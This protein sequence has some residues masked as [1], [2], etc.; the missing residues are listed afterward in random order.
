MQKRWTLSLALLAAVTGMLV[1][2]GATAAM[3]FP[4]VKKIGV[5]VPAWSS[6]PQ[7]W[8]L[9]AGLPMQKAFTLNDY[10]AAVGIVLVGLLVWPRSGERR[11]IAT[12]ATWLSLAVLVLV[13]ISEFVLHH[14]MDSYLQEIQR[15][16]IAGLSAQAADGHEAFS[17]LHPYAT[18]LMSAR[19]LLLLASSI[20]IFCAI[21]PRSAAATSQAP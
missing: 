12:L 9:V 11:T 1:A 5:L 15:A 7:A 3:A 20:A 8:L 16:N 2:T 21:T 14:K 4:T 6:D 13:V 10:A 19:L 17:K 18:Q